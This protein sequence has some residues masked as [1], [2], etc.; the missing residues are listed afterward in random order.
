MCEC[1]RRRGR[2]GEG[3]REEEKEKRHPFE[4]P[5]NITDFLFSP[6][7]IEA[8]PTAFSLSFP[9]G[10]AHETLLFIISN[11]RRLNKD[12]RICIKGKKRLVCCWPSKKTKYNKTECQARAMGLFFKNNK[13][14]SFPPGPG[15]PNKIKLSIGVDRVC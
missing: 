10:Q 8:A 14:L 3:E 6:F 15:Y 4:G 9:R 2:E 5:N 7:P 11:N 12:N 1:E 13:R